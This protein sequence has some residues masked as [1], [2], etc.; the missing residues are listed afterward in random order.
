ML[1]K[2]STK[3]FY[4]LL[5]LA[6]EREIFS[7]MVEIEKVDETTMFVLEKNYSRGIFFCT[8]RD[9]FFFRFTTP[10][11]F[12]YQSK[13]STVKHKNVQKPKT[14]SLF[15]ATRVLFSN[16]YLL[17][18]IAKRDQREASFKILLAHFTSSPVDKRP[19]YDLDECLTC[20]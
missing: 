7:F 17:L 15:E 19:Q 14:F 5:S 16:K 8:V 1:K 9:I 18:T 20:S 10:R 13:F 11:V 6:N 12:L 2:I 3:N 4:I